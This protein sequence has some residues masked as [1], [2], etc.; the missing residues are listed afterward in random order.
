MQGFRGT[1]AVR[2]FEGI[3]EECPE[4]GHFME[5]RRLGVHSTAPDDGRADFAF[6][7]SL[8]PCRRLFLAEYVRED[9]VYA[10]RSVGG[11]ATA[12][13]EYLARH[14]ASTHV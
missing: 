1:G 8:D 9:G 5:P 6:Q 10:L 13:D 4:C 2:T 12:H 14:G 7:C 3:P 11:V